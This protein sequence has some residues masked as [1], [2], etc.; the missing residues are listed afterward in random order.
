MIAILEMLAK[1]ILHPKT[2]KTVEFSLT[3][4]VQ[5]VGVGKPSE[6]QK[7]LNLVKGKIAKKNEDDL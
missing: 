1:T 5:L 4:G 6:I 7:L 3:N 2:Y